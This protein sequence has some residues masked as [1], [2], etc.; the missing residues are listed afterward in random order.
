MGVSGGCYPNRMANDVLTQREE[1]IAGPFDKA[2]WAAHGAKLMEIPKR[3]KW[4]IADWLV[5]GL[6]YLRGTLYA[7]AEKI[8]GIEREQLYN[9]AWVARRVPISLRSE[10]LSWSHHQALSGNAKLK[11]AGLIVLRDRAIENNWP[12]QTLRDEIRWYLYDQEKAAKEL[13]ESTGQDS[14]GKPTSSAFTA[15]MDRVRRIVHKIRA[16]TNEP[17]QSVY[18]YLF[19]VSGTAD[20]SDIKVADWDRMLHAIEQAGKAREAVILIGNAFQPPPYDS[21]LVA[22]P[23]TPTEWVNVTLRIRDDERKFINQVAKARGGRGARASDLVKQIL[24]DYF[25]A[26]MDSLKAEVKEAARQRKASKETKA[27]EVTR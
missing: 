5:A 19:R 3:F 24:G 1:T 2:E 12:V 6:P 8:T 4:A 13:A 25:K 17:T 26:N 22:P 20:L 7:E 9:W 10:K 21:T 18:S 11:E 15:Y 27:V 23:V 14:D 16:A